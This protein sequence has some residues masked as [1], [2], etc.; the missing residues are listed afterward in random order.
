MLVEVSLLDALFLR[1]PTG[2]FYQSI[3]RCLGFGLGVM[4][5]R[6]GTGMID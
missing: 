5:M 4:R 3:H 1:I 6:M 2:G